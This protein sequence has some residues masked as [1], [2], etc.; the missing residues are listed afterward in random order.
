MPTCRYHLLFSSAALCL[1]ESSG[2]PLFPP[3]WFMGYTFVSLLGGTMVCLLADLP[4]LQPSEK[5]QVINI[6]FYAESGAEEKEP[7]SQW[8][9][10]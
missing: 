1:Q 10:F 8:D 6:K 2:H 5:Q 7:S 9:S 3:A 4:A